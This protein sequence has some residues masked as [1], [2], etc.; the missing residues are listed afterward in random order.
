MKSFVGTPGYTAPEVI[1]GSDYDQK[2]DVWSLGVCLYAMMT[3]TLPFTPQNTNYRMLVEEASNITFPMSFSAQLT[4][5]LR[6]MFTIKPSNRPT[7][8][9]LQNHPWLH[10]LKQSPYNVTPKPIVFYQVDSI[11]DISKFK[12]RKIKPDANIIKKCVD[13]GINSEELTHDLELGHITDITT[14]YFCLLHPLMEKPEFHKPKAMMIPTKISHMPSNEKKYTALHKLAP[15][16]ITSSTTTLKS[17]GKA[18]IT[19]P[20]RVQLRHS[21]GRF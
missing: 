21:N 19:P 2:C 15:S 20:R 10:G 16:P 9:Q 11:E 7:L 17:A 1:T 14:T 6:K 4:D 13:Y 3:A 18:M 12:R 5:L 8:L